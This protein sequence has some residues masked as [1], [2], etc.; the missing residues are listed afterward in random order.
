MGG[1][2]WG[3]GGGVARAHEHL[4]TRLR[5]SGMAAPIVLKFGFLLGVHISIIT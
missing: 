4:Q 1:G 3:V 2:G 5:I